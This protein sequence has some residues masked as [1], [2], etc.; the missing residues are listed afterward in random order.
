MAM[1]FTACSPQA[2]ENKPVQIIATPA[3]DIYLAEVFAIPD[4]TLL[5]SGT[6]APVTFP[7]GLEKVYLGI[8]FN[9][10]GQDISK[11]NLNYE[12]DYKGVRLD[13]ELDSQPASWKEQASGLDIVILPV[14]KKDGSAFADGPYQA[15]LFIN[16]ELSA[17]LNFTVSSATPSP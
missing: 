12:L 14:R 5:S 1:L 2:A 13:T 7:S 6:P 11:F 9:K 15:K 3:G 10:Q 16:G 8:K 17:L 4:P